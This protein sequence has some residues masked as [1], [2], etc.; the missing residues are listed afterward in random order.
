MKN[1]V[2]PFKYDKKKKMRFSP[3]V[4]KVASTCNFPKFSFGGAPL[5]EEEEATLVVI[6]NSMVN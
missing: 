5:I 4:L 3:T 1:Q 2:N 6:C